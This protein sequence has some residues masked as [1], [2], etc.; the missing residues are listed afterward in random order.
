MVRPVSVRPISNSRS[1]SPKK[2][3]KTWKETAKEA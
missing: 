1:S 3:G 2:G